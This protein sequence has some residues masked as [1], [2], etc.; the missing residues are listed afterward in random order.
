LNSQNKPVRLGQSLRRLGLVISASALIILSG[1]G[2]GVTVYTPG[3]YKGATDP[4]V[5][6]SASPVLN[7]ELRARFEQV[8]ARQ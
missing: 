6:K 8:Q 2:E 3:E 1:C 7:E 5:A 4:F